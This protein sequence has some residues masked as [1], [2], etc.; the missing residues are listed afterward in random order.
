MHYAQQMRG[1]QVS[2]GKRLKAI[3]KEEK[4]SQR[5]FANE[6]NLSVTAIEHYIA[7]RR[8]PSGE[9]FIAMGSHEKFRKYTMWL[10]SGVVQPRSGQISPAFSTQEQCG[11]I[12]GEEDSQKKA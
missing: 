2:L 10:L 7:E 4:M 11:L 8:I 3:I 6:M 5:A 9:L 12:T 1:Y